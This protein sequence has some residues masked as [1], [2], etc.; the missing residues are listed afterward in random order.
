MVF[1]QLSTVEGIAL[2]VAT[3]LLAIPLG[4]MLYFHYYIYRTFSLYE[5][6]TIRKYVVTE[7]LLVLLLIL[8]LVLI[9][10]PPVTLVFAGI[11]FAVFVT[12]ILLLIRIRLLLSA[13]LC[14]SCRG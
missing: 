14:T 4:R 13:A 3:F 8:L 12:G 6:Y 2:V 7:M 1:E 5:L 9:Y 11:A 10:R